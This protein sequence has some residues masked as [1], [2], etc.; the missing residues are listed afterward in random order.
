MKILP[1]VF[2][3]L[4]AA[5]VWF[6]NSGE[7]E[8][9]GFLLQVITVF[10]VISAAAMAVYGDRIKRWWNRIDLRIEQAGQSDN[11]FNHIPGSGN[12]FCHH[13]R[14]INS[15]PTQPVTN[16]RVWLMRI[17]DA[18]DG[19][20]FEEK[21]KFAVPRLMSWAPTEYSPEARSFS[22]DQV[23]DLGRSFVE[24]GGRFQID[25]YGQG[26]IFKGDCLAGQTRR[27]MFKITAENYI[28]AGLVTVEICR[29]L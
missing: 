6:Y 5:A 10:G 27:Y 20:V 9:A 19:G 29:A 16:C 4:I 13:L 24:Q 26:G 18:T 21:F 17:F 25:A 8:Y 7:R 23:F 12:V 2:L 1:V 11:F 22:E 28:K 3:C 14:V 15:L